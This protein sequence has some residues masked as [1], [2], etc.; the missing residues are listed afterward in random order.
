M[1]GRGNALMTVNARAGPANPCGASAIKGFRELPRHAPGAVRIR[2]ARG[3]GV[4]G[5]ARLLRSKR[6]K[7][8][9]SDGLAVHQKP[10]PGLKVG[11]HVL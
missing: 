10:G 5:G 2:S 4:S 3:T 9:R 1:Q 6:G 7:I 8:S 11:L